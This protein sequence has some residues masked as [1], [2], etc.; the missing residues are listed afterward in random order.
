M[1]RW[2][3]PS[4]TRS[5]REQA[6]AW[7]LRW[8]GRMRT[9]RRPAWVCLA[10]PEG[11]ACAAMG[12]PSHDEALL[13]WR[14]W[15]GEHG[16]QHARLGLSARWLLSTV[17]PLDGTGAAARRHAQAQAVARWVHLLGLDEAAWQERWVT[18]AVALPGEML[19]CAVPKALVDDVMA[20]AA[21]HHVVLQ[22]VGPWWAHGLRHWLA[23][24]QQTAPSLPEAGHRALAMR[25]PGWAVHA[26]A[27]GAS[28]TRLWAEPDAGESIAGVPCVSL[29]SAPDATVRS[30]EALG[31]T[32]AGHAAVWGAMP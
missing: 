26:H 1:S 23:M 19:V 21:H 13:Q 8:R 5:W 3:T 12:V 6:Q 18:R 27:R 10:P 22:W 15:C 17:L 11:A 25:E 9:W 28:L 4:R 16:G 7:R 2:L 24:A 20:V 30:G 32:L 29:P 14:Q 31:Q